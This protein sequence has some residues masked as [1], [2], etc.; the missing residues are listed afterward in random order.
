MLSSELFT[1]GWSSTIH[2]CFTVLLFNFSGKKGKINIG[3]KDFKIFF[4]LVATV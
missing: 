4:K 1:P 2:N 3:P